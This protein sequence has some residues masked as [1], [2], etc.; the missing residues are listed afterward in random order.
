MENCNLL[1][2][3][4]TN[5]HYTNETKDLQNGSLST[6]K[7]EKKSNAEPVESTFATVKQR[8]VFAGFLMT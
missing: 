5:V 8:S 4:E 3:N 2:G 6:N 1:I 7:M